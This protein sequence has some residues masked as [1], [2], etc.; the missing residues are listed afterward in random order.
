MKETAKN[1]NRHI[2]RLYR[3]AGT[4][5][6]FCH[7]SISTFTIHPTCTVYVI[8]FVPLIFMKIL[9]N[10]ASPVCDNLD[11]F[12]IKKP[13]YSMSPTLFLACYC[14][15][16]QNMML[17]VDSNCILRHFNQYRVGVPSNVR[18]VTIWP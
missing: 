12:A 18:V 15:P 17:C 9:L 2:Y 1:D 8:M 6:V 7:L 10:E 14:L 11:Y 5:C 16:D 13:K 3:F 4:D